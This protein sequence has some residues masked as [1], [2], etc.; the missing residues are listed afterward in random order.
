[1]SIF[2]QRENTLVKKHLIIVLIL[3]FHWRL[4]L[5][6]RFTRLKTDQFPKVSNLGLE[7][8]SSDMPNSPPINLV[9]IWVLRYPIMTNN[10]TPNRQMFSRLCLSTFYRSLY[11]TLRTSRYWQDWN[12]Q[13]I[14]LPNWK[15]NFCFQLWL[16]L[17]NSK[18]AENP[19][20]S[21]KTEVLGLFWR[22]Q[23]TWVLVNLRRFWN[24]LKNVRKSKSVEHFHHSQ[25]FLWGV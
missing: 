6:L 3:G 23:S 16:V 22:I 11:L 13:R 24:Y 7:I 8:R 10:D 5:P 14:G 9:L 21:S 4:Y 18:H 19:L 20:G 1:M 2:G 17:L 15:L 25:S 12:N